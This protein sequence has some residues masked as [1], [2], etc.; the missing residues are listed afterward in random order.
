MTA[1]GG[2]LRFSPLHTWARVEDDGTVAV[3][4]TAHAEHELG[5]VQYVGLPRVGSAVKKDVAFGE[6]ES[7]K[8][9]S[10]LY[11]PCSGRVIAVNAPLVDD[12]SIVNREPYD[13]GWMIR[14]EPSHPPELESLLDETTYA[15]GAAAAGH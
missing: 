3:G 13:A 5:D 15:A 12:P 4:I 14:V 7:V 8:T 1:A 11:A 9:V 6:I 2:P 10:D